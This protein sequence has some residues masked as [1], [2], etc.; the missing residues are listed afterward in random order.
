MS[1]ENADIIAYFFCYGKEIVCGVNVSGYTK[2]GS[3]NC[4]QAEQVGGQR[5]CTGELCTLGKRKRE[6]RVAF[7]RHAWLRIGI[8]R[9]G[10]VAMDKKSLVFDRAWRS[11]WHLIS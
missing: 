7:D 5:W 2:V 4:N 8:S 9:V 1:L 11:L 10:K 3:F 6:G